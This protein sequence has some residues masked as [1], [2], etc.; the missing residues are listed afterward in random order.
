MNRSLSID[1][2]RTFVAIA[3]AGTFAAAA[4]VVGRSV[5]AVSLQID[6]LEEEVGQALFHKVGRRMQPT[7]AGRDLIDHARTI[8]AANDAAVAALA[9]DRLSGTVRLG[10]LHDAL[11]EAAGSVLAEFAALHPGAKLSVTVDTSRALVTALEAGSLD[12]VVAFDVQT[13]LPSEHLDTVPMR[14]ICARPGL[15]GHQRPLPLVLLDEPC[16]FRTAALAALDR[17]R[18]PYRIVLVS[19]SLAAVRAGVMAGLG[20]T[21]RTDHFLRASDGRAMAIAGLPALPA[22]QLRLYRGV[23]TITSRT[24][25]AL[26]R[27]MLERLAKS[28]S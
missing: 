5:S 10:V 20:M 23:E 8:L 25:G 7:A 28:G 22:K 16:A 13:R 11:E 19:A 1:Y 26:Q 17:A 12:Q 27:M 15:I 9:Q 24:G 6:R 3:D 4:A 21:A 14:W 18:I 2:L